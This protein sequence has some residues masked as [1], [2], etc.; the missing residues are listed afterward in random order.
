[1]LPLEGERKP[2][3]LLGTGFSEHDAKFSLD[4]RRIAYVSN[5][6]GRQ[7][8][9]VRPFLVDAKGTPSV[10]PRTLSPGTGEAL[11]T[12]ATMGRS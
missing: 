6:S 8:V 9:Y 11:H 10:G 2:I 12:G 4:G 7:E 5:E 1:M 3:R